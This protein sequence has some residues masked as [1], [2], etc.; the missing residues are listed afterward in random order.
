MKLFTYT[1]KQCNPKACTGAKLGRMGLAKTLQSSSKI[2]KDSIVLSPF[3]EKVITPADASFKKLT[4]LDCSWEHAQQVIPLIKSVNKRILPILVASNPV[5]YGK[6]T[7]LSTV[8]ALAGA[9]YILGNK[10]QS[11]SILG[12]FKW[13]PQ[14]LKLNENLLNDYAKCRKPEEV[15]EVQQKY[16]DL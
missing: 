16:F 14:F 2:P 5:N 9:L 12:V 7:K 3:A 6:P 10:E 8:E 4:A 13:G 1:A 15:L 11:E